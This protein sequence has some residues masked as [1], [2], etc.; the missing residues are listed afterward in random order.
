MAHKQQKPRLAPRFNCEW[1]DPDRLVR[2]AERGCR[3]IPYLT[4]YR[5]GYRRNAVEVKMWMLGPNGREVLE[6]VVMRG[7]W[8]CVAGWLRFRA[9]LTRAGGHYYG[10]T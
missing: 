4:R 1:R 8:P 6:T 3:G 5:I 7:W 2:D 10:N 9:D